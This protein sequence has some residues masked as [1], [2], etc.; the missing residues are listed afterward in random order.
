[1]PAGPALRPR[2][3]PT[4]SGPSAPFTHS[5]ID[6]DMQN[7]LRTSV[8]DSD[9]VFR[10]V[11]SD[12][13]N[14][15]SAIVSTCQPMGP[16]ADHSYLWGSHGA[17]GRHEGTWNCRIAT[18]GADLSMESNPVLDPAIVGEGGW[19]SDLLSPSFFSSSRGDGEPAGLPGNP[20]SPSDSRYRVPGLSFDRERQLGQQGRGSIA[21]ASPI[22]PT[23]S[24][25][26]LSLSGSEDIHASASQSQHSQRSPP[27]ASAIS[28]DNSLSDPVPLICRRRSIQDQSDSLSDLVRMSATSCGGTVLRPGMIGLGEAIK[29]TAEYPLRMLATTFRS[30]FIHQKLCRKSPRGM[31][32]PIAVALACVG[33]K[34]HSDQS[35]LPFVCD[36]FRDQR[37]KLI[38]ELVGF[39]S[40]GNIL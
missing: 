20:P 1:M 19:M 24:S 23:P 11:S 38:R 36:I 32:E 5:G 40:L 6:D 29:M 33:M 3:V 8:T 12:N 21:A 30:P 35:G 39:S 17:D 15:G 16:A 25:A 34:L 2:T 27:A 9:N 26:V 10:M 37:D 18:T 22:A 4:L 13:H 7:L 28:T 31:P 14:A